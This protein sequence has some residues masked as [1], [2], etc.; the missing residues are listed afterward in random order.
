MFVAA[1][2]DLFVVGHAAIALGSSDLGAA[3][4]WPIFFWLHVVF[5]NSFSSQQTLSLA[6]IS[7]AYTSYNLLLLGFLETVSFWGLLCLSAQSAFPSL[8]F[9]LCEIRCD[10]GTTLNVWDHRSL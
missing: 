1:H 3:S 9:Q 8:A 4:K 2:F 7:L 10:H 5:Y 6:C